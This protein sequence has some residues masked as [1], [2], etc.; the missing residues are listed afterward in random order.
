M[1]INWN[2]SY[3]NTDLNDQPQFTLFPLKSPVLRKIETL[4]KEIQAKFEKMEA[5]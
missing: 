3:N 4:L 5:E 2:L 1:D